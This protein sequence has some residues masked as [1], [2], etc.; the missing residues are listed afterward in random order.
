MNSRKLGF[1]FLALGIFGAGATTLAESNGF[2]SNFTS[3]DTN[4]WYVSNG[5][6]N[7]G[8][9]SCEWRADAISIKDDKLVFTVSDKGGKVRPIGCAEMHSHDRLG[10][11]MYEARL[12]TAAGSG[13]NTAFF[14]YIGP[15]DHEP[16]DEI[17]FE[18]LGK[19]PGKVEINH[20]A[21]GQKVVGK[22]VDLGFDSS[23]DFHDYAFDWSKDG[24][25][26]FID[27]VKVYE[28]PKGA[29]LPTHPPFM[30]LELWTGSEQEDSWMGHFDYKE[31]VT[32]EFEWTR[33]TP[34]P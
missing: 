16:W 22:I 4:R 11:G 1:F 33:Y 12:R 14:S 19:N 26:W 28:T 9:Q 23:K 34:H 20:T 30:F 17:D 25:K 27:G 5:W 3:I 6:A 15:S 8:H 10:T 7:G 18:F 31:P 32:A 13:L 2:R 29:P 21:G 24:I